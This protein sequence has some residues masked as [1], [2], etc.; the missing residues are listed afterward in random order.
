MSKTVVSI[1]DFGAE[2]FKE[3]GDLQTEKLQAAIDH[4]FACGGGEV[5]VP[6]GTFYTGGLRLR[7]NI[8][9]RLK[10]GATLLGSRNPEDYF[11]WREDRV[12]PLA[13]EDVTDH[14]WSRASQTHDYC[15]VRLPGSRWNCALIKAIDAENIAIIGEGNAAFDGADC[16][17]EAGEEF[18]RGPHGV[19]MFRCRNVLFRGYTFRNSANWAHA[20]FHCEN[21]LYEDVTVIAGHDGIHI[22][23][24]ANV[25]IAD[26]GFFT[27]DD[28]VAGFGNL[29]VSVTNCELNT[30]CSGMRFGGTNVFVKNCRF[31]G[32]A[33][34]FFRGSLTKEEKRDGAKPTAVHRY[35]ML[36]AFTYYADYSF[37][38]REQPG[39]IVIADCSIENTDRLLHFNYSGNETWQ[40]NRPLQSLRFENIIASGV[41]M[42]LT[43]YGDA[44]IPVILEIRNLKFAFR[45][46][47]ETIPFMHLCNFERITLESVKIANKSGAPLIK[48]WPGVTGRTEF[49]GVECSL[50]EDDFIQPADG[51]FVCR[52]I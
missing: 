11:G 22:T 46:G 25:K 35:N 38:I 8:T 6:A 42:P 21:I 9:L 13:P 19:N 28:C 33:K 48:L 45:E 52:P 34:Y 31:W 15:I 20:L 3:G 36:S 12:E 1:I 40:K 16:Y 7:S 44:E 32:P 43:A 29:N 17:D 51:P 18:Y 14:P 10:D 2:P 4:V 49:S 5:V 41:S 30:A 39:N 47:S 27:G 23:D 26:S 50:D 37:E 24:C